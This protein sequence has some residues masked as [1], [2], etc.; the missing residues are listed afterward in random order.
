MS[1]AERSRGLAL[2]RLLRQLLPGTHQRRPTAVGMGVPVARSFL[3]LDDEET[4]TYDGR[5]TP[6]VSLPALRAECIDAEESA[7]VEA[8]G[9]LGE[10]RSGRH[11]DPSLL[12]LSDADVEL[13]PTPKSNAVE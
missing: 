4:V 13:V 6:A 7:D 11:S 12:S 2:P 5:R 1:V 10:R 3:D 8:A 9:R